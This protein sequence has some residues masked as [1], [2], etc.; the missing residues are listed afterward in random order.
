MCFDVSNNNWITPQNIFVHEWKDIYCA[1]HANSSFI[2]SF[3]KHS[4][5]SVIAIL[6]SDIVIHPHVRSVVRCVIEYM[7]SASPARTPNN[8]NIYLHRTAIRLK[9]WS[10]DVAAR[11]RATRRMNEHRKCQVDGVFYRCHAE[12]LHILHCCSCHLCPGSLCVCVVYCEAV[13]QVKQCAPIRRVIEFINLRRVCFRTCSKCTEHIARPAT[14]SC[15][16]TA[17]APKA[18]NNWSMCNSA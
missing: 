4:T 13:W 5:S 18:L 9:R 16:S 11:A 15:A 8:S 2:N 6:Q 17:S 14:T 10:Y 3:V 1:A 12:Y 7:L